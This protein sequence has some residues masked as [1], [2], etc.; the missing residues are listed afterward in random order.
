MA[1]T[2]RTDSSPQFGKDY[3]MSELD[4]VYMSEAKSWKDLN[5]NKDN[6]VT[7][8]LPGQTLG[9]RSTT[10]A[11]KAKK[12]LRQLSLESELLPGTLSRCY[13]VMTDWGV[14]SGLWR[15]P[16]EILSSLKEAYNYDTLFGLSLF[17]PDHD[18]SLHHV[19]M[20]KQPSC[21]STCL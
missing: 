7:R 12:V 19:T 11:H 8:L 4:I 20:A 14:E 17:I 1:H 16:A 3:L 2:Q 13:S 5:L 10:L 21:I 15:A 9:S 6:L 18:H